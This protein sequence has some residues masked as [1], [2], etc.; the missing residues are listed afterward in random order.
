[1][2]TTTELENGQRVSHVFERQ[3]TRVGTVIDTSDPA[4]VCVEWDESLSA[5][6]RI[7]CMDPE[8][9]EIE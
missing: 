7:W 9:L 6:D 8:T 5:D 4:G 2:A 3:G 1:M